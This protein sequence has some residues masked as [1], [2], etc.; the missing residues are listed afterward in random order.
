MNKNSNLGISL[1]DAKEI[2]EYIKEYL[3]HGHFN[4][5]LECFENEIKLKQVHLR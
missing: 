5:T 3:Q 2:N 1:P 4:N